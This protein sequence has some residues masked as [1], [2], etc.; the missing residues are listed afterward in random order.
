MAH[1]RWK[2]QVI[3]TDRLAVARRSEAHGNG[4]VWWAREQEGCVCVG[5]T[6]ACTLERPGGGGQD[7]RP[8][9]QGARVRMV[10]LVVITVQ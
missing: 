1:T 6:G 3:A 7:G 4:M 2:A 10:Q 9:C 8:G 5:S